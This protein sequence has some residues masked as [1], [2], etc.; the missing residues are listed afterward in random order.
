M[1]NMNSKKIKEI[2]LFSFCKN[3]QNKWFVIFNIITLISIVLTLNW[4]NITSIINIKNEDIT[5]NVVVLDNVGIVYDE[6]EKDLS[7]NEKFNISKIEKNN[8]TKDNIPDNFMIV[9]IIEDKEDIFNVSIISKEGI[10]GEYFNPIKDELLKV[11]NNLLSKRYAISKETVDIFQRDVKINRKMLAV[12]AK[13]SD[14][15]E[16]IKLFS[17]ALIYIIAVFIFSKMA[18]EIASEK[19]SKSTE[20]VLTVVSE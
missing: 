19:Q 13:N 3:I 14:A 20:Y 18:N 15:K 7:K 9:E 8:Y 2:I 1:K 11:R 6:F 5:Y 16:I 17:S 10:Y 4:E 12:D